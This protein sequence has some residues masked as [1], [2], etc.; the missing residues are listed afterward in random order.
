MDGAVE[1]SRPNSALAGPGVRPSVCNRD[2]MK[3]FKRKFV[4]LALLRLRSTLQALS[5]TKEDVIAQRVAKYHSNLFGS[6]LP[7]TCILSQTCSA[8]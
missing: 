4:A 2:K 3:N 7:S 1:V 8:G 5:L 6:H